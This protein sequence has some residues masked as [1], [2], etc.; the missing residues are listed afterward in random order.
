M[1]M[2]AVILG[3]TGKMGRWLA[4]FLKDKG[5]EV[6]IHSRS[7]QREAKTAEELDVKY[8]ESLDAI[9]NADM[10]IVATSLDSTVET[11]HKTSKKMKK[12]SSTSC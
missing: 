4:K 3:G 2:R 5:F 7:S 8:I 1:E 12:N 6:A 11:I 9:K 10:V